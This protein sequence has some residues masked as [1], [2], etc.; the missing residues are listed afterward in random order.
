ME[1]RGGGMS[2]S[3]S[4]PRRRFGTGSGTASATPAGGAC[5]SWGRQELQIG[6]ITS[7]VQS[8][9]RSH[10]SNART[11]SPQ[12]AHLLTAVVVWMSLL[13]VV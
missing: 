9:N 8:M 12:P 1:G 10:S 11:G 5:Y 6:Q 4:S 3:M 2:F 13:G 7:E